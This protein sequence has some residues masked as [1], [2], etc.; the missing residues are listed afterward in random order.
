M[1]GE[2]GRERLSLARGTTATPH[3]QDWY[4]WLYKYRFG[5]QAGTGLSRIASGQTPLCR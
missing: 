2:G 5:D 4:V 3:R 1:S